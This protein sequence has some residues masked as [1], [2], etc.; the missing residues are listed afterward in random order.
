MK[1]IRGEKRGEIM[2][3][4]KGDEGRGGERDYMRGERL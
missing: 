3:A 4:G 1:E 2:G